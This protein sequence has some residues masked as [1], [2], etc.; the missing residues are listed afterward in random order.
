MYPPLVA[1]DAL[2]GK[3]WWVSQLFFCVNI[4]RLLL[5]PL[6]CASATLHSLIPI[7]PRA[8]PA[9]AGIGERATNLTNQKQ[10]EGELQIL[11]GQIM[12]RIY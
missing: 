4:G 9:T 7:I 1:E 11:I 12:R 2:D 6:G 3:E 5:L 10:G 8:T